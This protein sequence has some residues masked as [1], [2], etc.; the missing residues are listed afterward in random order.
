MVGFKLR[1]LLH[2]LGLV[3]FVLLAMQF[4]SYLGLLTI[5]KAECDERKIFKQGVK[6]S[7]HQMQDSSTFPR[8]GR[9]P[10]SETSN[11]FQDN[12]LQSIN[13]E[14]KRLAAELSETQRNLVSSVTNYHRLGQHIHFLHSI[15]R[16][17]SKENF[18]NTNSD[19][20]RADAKSTQ[21]S[22]NTQEVCPET[23]KG[24]DLSYGY[25]YFRKGFDIENCSDFVPINKLV[26]ILI[27]L[28]KELSTSEHLDIFKG[29][30]SYYP[31]IRVVLAVKEKI[32]SEFVSTISNLKIDFKTIVSKD[33]SEGLVWSKL[34]VEVDTPYVMFAP[35]ITHFTDDV[36]LERLVRVLSY[37][38]DTIISGGSHR[39]LRGEWDIG[40][41]QVLF[42]NWTAHN[43]G[44]Y[45][46]SFSECV[47]CD[48]LSGPFVAKT[49]QINHFGLD[50]RWVVSK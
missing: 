8:G 41:L 37:N 15:I 13:N 40:C 44:G 23:F 18:I 24:K 35:E 31:N 26:T 34:L 33:F 29:I 20:H 12:D 50:N 39:N 42:R 5:Q 45:Y 17:L 1:W 11:T 4:F 21:R 10:F 9:S 2:R 6:I 3:A 43:R 28:P 16:S 14:L 30:A 22:S 32:S 25:P 49:E 36:N 19:P 47:V 46:R 48:V 38:K 7:S 27:V